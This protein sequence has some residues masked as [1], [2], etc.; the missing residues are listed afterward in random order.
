MLCEVAQLCECPGDVAVRGP[1]A[2]V[3]T[4]SNLALAKPSCYRHPKTAN[5]RCNCNRLALTALHAIALQA[6]LLGGVPKKPF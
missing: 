4:R 1:Q 3:Q 6:A 5:K 2:A